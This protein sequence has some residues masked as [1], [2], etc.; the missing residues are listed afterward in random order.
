MST[1][2]TRPAA[3][4]TSRSRKWRPPAWNPT[5][6]KHLPA[7]PCRH[8]LAGR[9]QDRRPSRHVARPRGILVTLRTTADG[10]KV[11]DFRG[12]C[13]DC[14]LRL[15][16]TH[17]N[18]PH[19]LPSSRH[20][21]RRC[22]RDSAISWLVRPAIEEY[23]PG[24]S[25][26]SPPDAPQARRSPGA[27]MR[28]RLRIGS[29]TS[30]YSPPRSTSHAWHRCASVEGRRAGRALH[31]QRHQICDSTENASH[32]LRPALTIPLTQWPRPL[33]LRAARKTPAF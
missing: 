4:R 25:A 31:A 27:R 17:P 11:G 13:V 15:R 23:R 28:G 20:G 32:W 26:R 12:R 6:R 30:R 3:P 18:R 16:C 5:W 7:P 9:L 2:A 10:S 8:V 14:P 19:H 1:T 29:A 21:A 22:A 24:L 33:T